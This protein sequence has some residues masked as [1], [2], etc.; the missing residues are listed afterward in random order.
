MTA[1][2]RAG[3]F[4]N[5]AYRKLAYVG[6]AAA[7]VVTGA[8]TVAPA[9]QAATATEVGAANATLSLLNQERAANRLP[10]MGM[11]SA[12]ISSAHRHNLAMARANTLSHQLPGE[13]VFSTRIS[14]A[15]VAW[16]AAAENVGYTT[17]R[18]AAGSESLETAMYNEVAPDNGHRLNILST[19]T[20]YVGID[21]YLD[22]ATGKL[23]L[24]EDFAD[25]AGPAA[26]P[27]AAQISQAQLAKH[28][29]FGGLSPSTAAMPNHKLRVVGWAI[30]PENKRQPLAVSVW[31]DGHLVGRAIV[32]V[33]RPDI[34]KAYRAGP[35]QGF[36]FVM[37]VPA[38]KHTIKVYATNIGL[39]TA[40]T[41]MGTRTWVW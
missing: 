8:L 10:A 17:N 32:P 18:T 3:F 39:G 23:W 40:S 30:D 1:Q 21:V 2:P 4:R 7:I 28:N 25:V 11:S 24:T 16:H 19:A 41:L 29:P 9:A 34:E 12:L 31:S 38:G 27:A 6:T 26:A 22:S 15:G 35:N 33:G 37:A 20:R 13:P 36:N 14:Q 5:L